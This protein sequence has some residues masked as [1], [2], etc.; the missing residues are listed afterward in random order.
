MREAREMIDVGHH[1]WHHAWE[2]RE[3]KETDVDHQE[4]CNDM[5]HERSKR[6]WCRAGLHF[7]QREMALSVMI[8]I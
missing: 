8:V 3:A 2:M 5:G 6:D 1:E 4:W 7:P